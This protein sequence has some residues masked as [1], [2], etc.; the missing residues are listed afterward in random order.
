MTYICASNLTITD[1]DNGLS[2]K[3]RQAII[4]TI[5]GILLI[6]PLEIKLN[7]ILIEIYTI[8]FNK[9]HLKMSCGEWRPF[10]PDLNEFMW[11]AIW[12]CYKRTK[13]KLTKHGLE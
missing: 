5:G 11:F 2:P 8:A 4:R 9:M 7:E 13:V 12:L 1:S 3:R 6:G 10:C